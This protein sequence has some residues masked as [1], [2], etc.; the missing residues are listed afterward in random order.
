[1]G[2]SA[3]CPDV[4][5]SHLVSAKR[6]AGEKT[7]EGPW[8]RRIAGEDDRLNLRRGAPNAGNLEGICEGPAQEKS[9]YGWLAVGAVGREPVST[10]NSLLTGKI[11]GNFDEVALFELWHARLE[12][13][14]GALTKN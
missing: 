5:A 9:P 1:V 7:P 13:L 3:T 8:K 6:S 14:F 10:A 12:A 11:T 4:A 2:Y